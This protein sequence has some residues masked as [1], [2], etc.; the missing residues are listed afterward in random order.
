LGPAPTPEQAESFAALGARIL[1]T[2]LPLEW[3]APEPGIVHGA[4]RQ[5]ARLAHDL[6][7][8]L[9]HLNSPA[10]AATAPFLCPV[11]SVCH[12][13][14][15]TWWA[16]VRGGPLPED[17]AWRAA[18]TGQGLGNSDAV[19]V[20]TAAFGA[21]LRTAYDLSTFPEVVWNGRTPAD[22]GNWTGT[23]APYAFT[24]GR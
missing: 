11:V 9:V 10:L 6:R 7:I 23:L 15:A 4:G 8:D 19:I 1:S 3:T 20:P 12:S 2:G 24:A 5:I 22:I 17:F 14:L 13:C 18:L 16:A 21:A